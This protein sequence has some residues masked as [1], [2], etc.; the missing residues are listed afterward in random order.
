MFNKINLNLDVIR[1]LPVSCPA[2]SR[3]DAPAA[4]WSRIRPPFWSLHCY[5]CKQIFVRTT[6]F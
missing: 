6:D 3:A 2:T 5:H 4:G 1:D